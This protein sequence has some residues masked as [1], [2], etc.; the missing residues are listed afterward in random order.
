MGAAAAVSLFLVYAFWPRPIIV[1]VGEAALGPMVVTINEEARTRVRDAY[2]VSAPITGRMMRVDVEPGDAVVGGVTVV[3]R[4]LPANPELLDARAADQARAGIEA[5]QAALE[6]AVSDVKRAQA[7][8]DYAGLEMERI[9]KLYKES[10]AS[11]DALDRADRASRSARATLETANAAVSMRRAELENARAMFRFV[12]EGQRPDDHS[13]P[14]AKDSVELK[15]PISGRVLRTM[16][17]SEALVTAGSSILEIGDTAND[18]EI[19]AELLST[20]AVDVAKG[21]R[22]LIEKWGGDHSLSGEVER[23]EPWGFTKFS[24]LGV[25]EQ[26]VNVIIR[27]TD[28]PA[29]REALGHGFRV[30]ARIVTWEDGNALSIPSSALFRD[31][32]AWAVFVVE[33]GRTQARAVEVGHNNGVQAEIHG[34]LEAGEEVVLY[35]GA[36]LVDGTRVAIR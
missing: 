26:R 2:V 13:D 33:G 22:V 14:L 3:A 6:F 20:D 11:Q 19:V 15:A 29:V 35:P 4:L 31:G 18:L 7:E 25:E 28:P 12:P 30:E 24:A 36:E 16:Q 17:K 23:V 9:R 27:F 8:A 34:G 10:F 32:D 21:D 1:Q 5:A